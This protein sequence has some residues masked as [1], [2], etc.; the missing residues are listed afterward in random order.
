[1]KLVE[2]PRDAI[3]GITSFI[4]TEKKVLYLNELL[5]VGFDT[6][7]FGSFVSPKA[8]PQMADTGEVLKQLDLSSA[9]A[10][11]LAITANKRGAEEAVKFP[12]ISYLG[13]P[14]SISE[15]FQLRNTGKTISQSVE[16]VKSIAELC[17]KYEKEL[18]IYI[19]MG[20]GNPYGEEWEPEIAEK[21][22]EQ[23]SRLNI[24]IFS[25]S[26]TVGIAEP[27]L[28]GNLFGKLTLAFPNLEFGAH[29]H[30]NP[31]TW[32]EKI[33]AAWTAGCRRFD[34]AIAGYGGCPMAAD[35]LVGNMPTEN[36]VEFLR[37]KGVENLPSETEISQLKLSFHDLIN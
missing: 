12:E 13:Y 37:G 27:A 24:S 15:T 36:L 23:L 11:L 16:E 19:S 5:Q 1:M 9:K 28:I 8:V 18:V 7:D 31:G 34:G 32:V 20:F 22:V 33:E 29:F 26:D 2:C 10:K 3:Q 30:T 14:F 6:I 4:P 35:K 21:W 25:L 17:E